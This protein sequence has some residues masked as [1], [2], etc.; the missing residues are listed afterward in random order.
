MFGNTTGTSA[1]PAPAP[2]AGSLAP[3]PTA[4]GTPPPAPPAPPPP[5][6]PVSFIPCGSLPPL[7]PPPAPALGVV[8]A[9]LPP[10]QAAS[11]AQ[12]I[13]APKRLVTSEDSPIDEC[14]EL[15]S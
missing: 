13:S 15:A 8:S 14:C 3:P 10:P 12:T 4:A 7:A 2:P 5:G 6:L 1:E 11:S 9:F